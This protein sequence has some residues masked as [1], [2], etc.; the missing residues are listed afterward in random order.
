MNIQQAKR[1]PLEHILEKLGHKPHHERHGELWYVSPFR[2]EAE[3]SFKIN[4]AR[5]IWYDFGRGQG[6][7]VIDFMMAYHHCNTVS[8][9]LRRCDEL[10]GLPL[11][12]RSAPV[13][14]VASAGD[15]DKTEVMPLQNRALI[16]YLRKRGI[17]MEIAQ[18]YV[19]EIHYTR[20]GKPY[21][22]LAFPNQAGGY[23]M[24]NPYFKGVHGHKD[25]T[26]LSPPGETLNTSS[27]LVFEGFFDFLSYLAHEGKAALGAPVIVLNSVAMKDKALAVIREKGFAQVDL[28]LDNDVPGR[29]LAGAFQAA[30]PGITV[31]D[32]SGLYRDFKDY[33]A[34]LVQQAAFKGW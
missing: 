29:E 7:N 24:R 16:G 30:L 18:P 23:E 32:C 8:D 5:N 1:L 15:N 4:P 20:A 2:Q 11:V 19:Q 22:A 17:P 21:F 34:F 27:V 31:R 14:K 33:N 9:A 26:F 28:Y 3:P 25:I 6:G 10:E 13:P 12:E